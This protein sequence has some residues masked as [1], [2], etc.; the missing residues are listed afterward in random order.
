MMRHYMT[1][2]FVICAACGGGGGTSMEGMYMIDA[3]NANPTSCADPGP[4]LI[5][6]RSETVFYIENVS[7]LGQSFINAHSCDTLAECE[8]DAAEETIYIDGFGGWEEGNDDDGWTDSFAFAFEDFT[9]PT[10]C[11]GSITTSTLTADGETGVILRTEHVDTP[12]F[13]KNAGECVDEDALAAGAGL[14]CGD[15]EIV[16]GT[17]IGDI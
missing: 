1:G 14:P 3:W 6:V 13:P 16:H 4:T 7:F 10:M 12:L 2:L 8:A 15:L 5:G 11:Q 9:D 17:K